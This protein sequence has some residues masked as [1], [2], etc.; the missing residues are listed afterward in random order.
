MSSFLSA[1]GKK[2]TDVRTFLRE[3]AGGNTLKYKPAKGRKHCVY[4]PYKTSKVIED[5]V[6]KPVRELIAISGKVHE[7]TDDGKYKA[8]ICLDGVAREDE[9]GN[10]LND[11]NCPFCDSVGKAWEIYKYRI[12]QEE[13][14]GTPAEQIKNLKSS[15][16]DDRKSK[17][18]KEYIYLLV[19]LYRMDENKNTIILS[20]KGIPE[21]DLKVM[22]L[23][24]AR[25]EKIQQQMEN[26]G[27]ELMGGEIAFEYPNTDDV[28]LLVSQST[29][30]PIFE[31][32]MFIKQYEGLQTAIDEAVSKFEWE[33]IEKSFTEW[34]G[35]TS[36]EAEITVKK[37]FSAWDTYQEEIK[38]N[39]NAKYLEYVGVQQSAVN[40]AIDGGVG[41]VPGIPPV[42]EAMPDVNSLFGKSAAPV[43]PGVPAVPTPAVPVQQTVP[44]T[45]VAPV[46]P[47][48]PTAPATPVAPVVPGVPTAPVVPGVPTV[49]GVPNA[50]DINI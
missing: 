12:E 42:G 27:G 1:A 3:A 15:F 11:G 38:T 14:N 24:V 19:A 2:T 46:V 20:D 23:S 40:P 44:E 4:I 16:A 33:G 25:V 17:E 45:P 6:E 8:T 32:K 29:T 47:G 31:S 10:I 26:S 21:F 9:A 7:W 13:A 39:P 35:M 34:R 22:K 50:G 30:T 49:P 48:V 5:G 28:R 18:A 43:V 37:L 41:A 36:K